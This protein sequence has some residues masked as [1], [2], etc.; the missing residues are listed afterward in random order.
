MRILRCF[1]IATRLIDIEH[2]HRYSPV[3]KKQDTHR[4]EVTESVWKPNRPLSVAFSVRRMV[5]RAEWMLTGYVG[6]PIN[7]IQYTVL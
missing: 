2:V 3:K 4:G 1:I 7:Q 6:G 5:R